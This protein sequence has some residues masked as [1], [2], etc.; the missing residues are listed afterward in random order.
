[1]IRVLCLSVIIDTAQE[2]SIARVKE[3]EI[4][5]EGFSSGLKRR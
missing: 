1:M 5:P 2:D 4:L 3:T